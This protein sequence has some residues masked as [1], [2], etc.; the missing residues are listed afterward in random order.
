VAFASPEPGCSRR[1]KSATLRYRRVSAAEVNGKTR[2]VEGSGLIGNATVLEVVSPTCT[3]TVALPADASR[4]AGMPA[5]SCVLLT[6]VVLSGT[7]LRRTVANVVN[8]HR[9]R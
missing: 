4:L 5:I 2:E 9:S 8:P 1:S 6:R 3:W 7:R